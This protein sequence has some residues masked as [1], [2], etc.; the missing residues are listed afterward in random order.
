MVPWLLAEE[1][2]MCLKAFVG[3]EEHV[4]ELSKRLNCC[5]NTSQGRP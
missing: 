3:L 4:H 2:V 5:W 1:G